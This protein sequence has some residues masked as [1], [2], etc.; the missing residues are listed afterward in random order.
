MSGFAGRF[1]GAIEKDTEIKLLQEVEAYEDKRKFMVRVKERIANNS[2]VDEGI[3]DVLKDYVTEDNFKKNEDNLAN[4][5][6]RLM[7][8]RSIHE[9]ERS[10]NTKKGGRGKSRRRRQN[11][12]KTKKRNAF[13]K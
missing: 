12:N 3:L 7:R 4:A 6:A 10:S 11:K 13:Y 9:Y 2:I 1:R 8:F 5:K